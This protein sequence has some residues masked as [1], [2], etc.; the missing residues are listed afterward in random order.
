M[1][2]VLFSRL[3]ELHQRKPETKVLLQADRQLSYEKVMEIVDLI[4]LSGFSEVGLIAKP[5]QKSI[6][7]R[8]GRE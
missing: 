8:G 3:Q 7:E 2:E 1:N 6:G 4:S 5:K